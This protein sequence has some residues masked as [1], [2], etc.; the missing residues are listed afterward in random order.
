MKI[1]FFNTYVAKD[2]KK[3]VGDL[4]DSTMLSEG[5]VTALFETKLIDTFGFKNIISLN[6]GTSA[7]HLALDLCNVQAGD[8]VI[9]PAQTFVATGLA[10]L[11][12]KAQ[13]IFA[14]INYEDGNINID[15]IK[16]KITPQTKAI[17]CVHWG[18]NPCQMAE[19]KAICKNHNLFLIEDAAHALG[20]TYREQ[21]IGNI[22]DITCFSFQAIKHLTTGD[23]GA[24][25]VNSDEL[26]EKALQ[27][28]WFGIDRKNAALS[29]LGERQYNLKEVGYKYHMNNYAAA[30]GLANIQ[31]YNERL[32]ARQEIANY[33]SNQLNAI[34]GLQLFK[35][36]EDRKNAWWLYGMHVENRIEFIRY[37]AMHGIPAS[38][39]HQRI[40][41]NDVLG[42]VD[43]SLENQT[44]FDTTQIHIPIH[45]AINSETAEYICNT[46]KKGW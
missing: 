15:S 32:K 6:S 9:I 20:A 42:G 35:A 5:K 29:E 24:I 23:G 44:R 37:L 21:T 28:K 41:R 7:L 11:Y 8:E 45:D 14:D 13:P 17:I 39:V 27:K 19:L 40:D 31:H 38:V 16:Q 25:S 22:S 2:A 30:L 12:C 33:Y 26:Y 43:L 46:I 3:I 10:V 1:D 36:W 18:G 4:M 34:A